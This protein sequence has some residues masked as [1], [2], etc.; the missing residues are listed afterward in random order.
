MQRYTF[1]F[2]F[3]F[4]D[5]KIIVASAEGAILLLEKSMI[6]LHKT[7]ESWTINCDGLMGVAKEAGKGV[8]L[9]D[10]D[11]MVIH[12]TDKEVSSVGGDSELPRM[13]SCWLRSDFGQLAV[14]RVH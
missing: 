12:A 6:R 2:I 14:M 3:V 10:L 9:E 4:K 11:H 1:L 7:N 8:S 13:A 5:R